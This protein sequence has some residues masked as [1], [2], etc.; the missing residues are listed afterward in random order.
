[1]IFDRNSSQA[2]INIKLNIVT[3]QNILIFLIN[4]NHFIPF[5][6]LIIITG[7]GNGINLI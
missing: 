4:F 3:F 6:T 5:N 7:N 1:L 2:S